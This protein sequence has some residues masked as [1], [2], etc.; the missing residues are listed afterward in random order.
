MAA[1]DAQGYVGQR[2]DLSTGRTVGY[3]FVLF[4]EP[5]TRAEFVTSALQIFAARAAAELERRR[6]E[7]RLREQA[8][9][10][11]AA[12]EAILV[13]DLEDRITYWNKG[14]ERMYGWTAEEV[15]GL[16]TRDLLN[17]DPVRFEE[18]FPSVLEREAWNGQLVKR[19]KS[20][21]EITVESS[22]TLVRDAQGQPKSILVINTDITARLRAEAE[23]A[24]AREDMLVELEQRVAQRTEALYAATQ[25]AERANRA[26]S[27]F[28]SR[29]S[30]ELRTPL[31][32]I[33]GFAQLLETG[34]PKRRG[35]RRAWR[36]SSAPENICSG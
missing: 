36:R 3:L 11:D 4:R 17:T 34:R 35:Q 5:L 21:G 22:W 20:D 27:E 9:L 10:L 2:L 8:A 14:S 24:Q 19:T 6:S 16:R 25:E 12:H 31:H 30:H 18:A 32:A 23:L 13:K 33:L 29:M 7:A 28:L 26:K 1:L 15:L